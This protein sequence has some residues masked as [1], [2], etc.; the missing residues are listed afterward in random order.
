MKKAAIALA[1]I[2]VTTQLYAAF[3][4]MEHVASV[5]SKIEARHAIAMA[6]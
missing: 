5:A 3:G 6:Q 2:L 4:A 1:A